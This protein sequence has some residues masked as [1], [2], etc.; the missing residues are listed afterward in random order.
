[1]LCLLC[2]FA[3]AQS[4][5]LPI[6]TKLDTVAESTLITGAAEST[7]PTEAPQN[8]P[9]QTEDGQLLWPMMPTETLAQLAKT[10]YP[11]SPILEQR[12]IQKTIR[13]TK[14]LGVTLLPDT[15]F[16]RVQVIAIPDEKEVRAMTHRIK[17]LEEITH[18]QSQLKLSYQL[19]LS[20]QLKKIIPPAPKP[21]KTIHQ[22][23]AVPVPLTKPPAQ[24]LPKPTPPTFKVP[25][26]PVHTQWAHVWQQIQSTVSS[27]SVAAKAY[28]SIAAA[29][30]MQHPQWRNSMYLGLLV[31][32]GIGVWRLQKRYIRKQVA[33]LNTITTTLEDT[34]LEETS[35]DTAAV[36][37]VAMRTPYH[38]NVHEEDRSAAA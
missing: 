26:T 35:S 32:V 15:P 24:V 38:Q 30:V 7:F 6:E 5:D 12:F 20:D 4:A 17:R 14:T 37:T 2:P 19:K 1:M 23:Q 25:D 22:P 3:L 33:L 8:I 36:P 21:S 34:A 27:W 13:L 18:E 31:L 10:F 28:W 29:K 11:D 9:V 16:K